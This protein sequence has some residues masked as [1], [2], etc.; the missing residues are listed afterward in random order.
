M[1]A[2]AAQGNS[3]TQCEIIQRHLKDFGSITPH[4]A[5]KDYG[6]MRLTSRISELKKAGVPIDKVMVRG[7]NR[8]GSP[9]CYAQYILGGNDVRS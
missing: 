1:E 6:I 8:Y 4:E 9:T 3:M 7:K 5:M 2:L